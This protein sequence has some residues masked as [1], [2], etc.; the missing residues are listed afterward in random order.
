[1]VF[2]TFLITTTSLIVVII[3]DFN[4]ITRSDDLFITKSSTFIPFPVS[5]KLTPTFYFSPITNVY[6]Y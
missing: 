4:S 3:F 6:V 2:A 5:F 1:M